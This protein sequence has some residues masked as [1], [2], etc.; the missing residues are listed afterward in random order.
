MKKRQNPKVIKIP[1][2][3]PDQ[4]DEHLYSLLLFF[5][6]FQKESIFS[7]F[8]SIKAAYEALKS[9]FR[10][11]DD[12]EIIPGSFA[13]ELERMLLRIQTLVDA[14]DQEE[15]DETV[16]NQVDTLE[17]EE[18]VANEQQNVIENPRRQTFNMA[19]F[20]ARVGT[21]NREQMKV[22][23]IVDK[24]VEKILSYNT[25]LEPLRLFVSGGGVVGKSY[26]INLL[27]E[28]ITQKLY[29]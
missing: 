3:Q 16:E 23:R 17:Y 5:Y 22:F 13:E 10:T 26:L 14:E 9:H 21:L 7:Q 11:H 12:N 27:D 18:E 28:L 15:D 4:L 2:F 20:K 1:R 25:N 24:Q 8:E 19:A 6:P 29:H